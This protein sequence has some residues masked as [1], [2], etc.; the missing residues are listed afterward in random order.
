[1]IP[2]IIHQIWIGPLPAPLAWM[3]T[4]RDMNPVW[5]YRVWSENDIR[6]L[7]L[8]NQRV[9]DAYIADGWYAGASNIVRAEILDRIGGVHAD[10][11][12]EC[13]KPLD[14]GAFIKGDFFAAWEHDGLDIDG[15]PLVGTSVMGSVPRHEVGRRFL[16]IHSDAKEINPS[17]RHTG[18]LSLSKCIEGFES[19]ILKSGTF[20]PHHHS[21][22]E[23]NRVR[24]GP[25]A[26]QHW[27][28]TNKTKIQETYARGRA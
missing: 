26:R 12:S 24:G 19:N 3:Q 1:M 9:Y 8:R 10:A 15:I 18:P 23:A 21:K 11:D 2:R 25:F 7:G 28:S 4:W 17:W 16:K 27:G 20:Y 5:A 14:K 22:G 6:L 13:L